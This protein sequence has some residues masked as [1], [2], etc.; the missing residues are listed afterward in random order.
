MLINLRLPRVLTGIFCCLVLGLSTSQ[1]ALAENVTVS[2]LTF[3]VDEI[4]P[5]DER[6][7]KI[8]LFGSPQIV[9]RDGLEDFVVNEYFAEAARVGHFTSRALQDFI[10]DS[11]KQRRFARVLKAFPHWC[12]KATNSEA[13]HGLLDR[14]DGQVVSAEI[15]KLVITERATSG[16]GAEVMSRLVFFAGLG[17]SNWMRTNGI[18]IAIETEMVLR[19]LLKLRIREAGLS[20][21]FTQMSMMI[22]FFG[23]AFGIDDVE[24][25]ELRRAH[26][27][28][29]EAIDDIKRSNLDRIYEL[30][31]ISRGDEWLSSVI[32]PLLIESLHQ[33]AESRL[34]RGDLEGALEVV[35]HID[36]KKRTLTTH[37][38]LR[39]I[40]V[41]LVPRPG[42][43]AEDSSITHFMRTVSLAD[44]AVA[45]A[46][47][48][49]LQ[50]EVNNWL[51]QGQLDQAQR[52]LEKLLLVR[53]DPSAENDRIRIEI[54][55]QLIER[56]LFSLARVRLSEI[57][58]GI[59]LASHVR[60]LFS[61]LYF[62]IRYIY[63]LCLS[64]LLAGFVL[65]CLEKWRGYQALVAAR[66][67]AAKAKVANAEEAEEVV[68][69]QFISSN[70]LRSV[71]PSFIEYRECLATFGLLE[72]ADL[73]KI[74]AAYRQAVKEAHPDHLGTSQDSKASERFI[75][76][77]KTYERLME[78]HQ[79]V[80]EQISKK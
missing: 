41:D 66:I 64:P 38:I 33:T 32:S 60:L 79:I 72:G 71:N 65:F 24:Y 31:E 11:I 78:L 3:A 75:H 20:R 23:A 17:D 47:V 5:I 19:P 46:Y 69:P 67:A 70:F 9:S 74:K 4:S 61:G 8:L 80:G 76:L 39:R 57:Q 35:T 68:R 52:S 29:T 62:D 21:N 7:V 55:S 73:K 14:L 6:Q 42:S 34:R 37:D 40:L 16:C 1:T 30:V 63:I 56:N 53:K 45:L 28:V 18:R 49:F 26:L 22:D 54:I 2:G 43:I 44:E 27:K 15:A 12:R 51:A 13:M 77:T 36:L 25:G 59:P 50:R 48:A 10:L 58:T